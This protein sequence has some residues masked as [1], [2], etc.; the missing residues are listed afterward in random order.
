[1]G[2]AQGPW[3]RRVRST[4][5]EHGWKEDWTRID[6]DDQRRGGR[7]KLRQERA[8]ASRRTP[9]WPS[10]PVSPSPARGEGEGVVGVAGTS[11]LKV[12]WAGMTMVVCG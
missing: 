1:M 11:V 2:G 3:S 10:P 12:G 4:T 9:H 7:R 5:D 6:A 8:A